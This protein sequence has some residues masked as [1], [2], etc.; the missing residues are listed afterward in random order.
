LYLLPTQS[1][2]VAE[3][4]AKVQGDYPDALTNYREATQR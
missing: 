3:A 2:A 1:E 4:I